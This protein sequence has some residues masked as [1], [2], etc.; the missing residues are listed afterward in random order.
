[1]MTEA[2]ATMLPNSRNRAAEAQAGL[3]EAFMQNQERCSGREADLVGE[4]VQA[5]LQQ[6][7][8]AHQRIHLGQRWVPVAGRIRPR[9]RA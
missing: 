7:L 1:M 4:P 8:G 3:Q 6:R 9:L 2:G 5:A